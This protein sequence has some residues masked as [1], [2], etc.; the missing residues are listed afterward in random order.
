M[1]INLSIIIPVY[2]SKKTLV[3]SLNSINDQLIKKKIKIEII[4]I[5]D[6]G[7]NY[8]HIIPKMRNG[9]IVK[10]YKSKGIKTGP[11]NARNVGIKKAKGEYIGYLD[12][13]DEWSSNFLEKMYQAVKKCGIAFSA[14]RV[15]SNEKLLGEFVGK[16]KKYLSL[17]D[18]G[19]IPCS[20]HPFVKKKNQILFENLKSQ[21]VYNSA[22]LLNK[23]NKK[24]QIT[25]DAYYK[26]NLQTKSVTTEEGFSH[27]INLAYK[28]YQIKSLK[29]RNNKMARVFAIRRIINKKFIEWNKS[30]NKSFYNFMSWRI[31]NE[32]RKSVNF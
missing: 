31:K 27:K 24:I 18:I 8:K 12:A 19:E 16:N 3:K 26:M 11:G 25:K 21:D 9:T 29:L 1:K 20:F 13:D 7:K 6:D 14:T 10:I 30:N 23:K 28:K 2:N 32:R 4:I 22:Y 17:S 15:Y 5:I